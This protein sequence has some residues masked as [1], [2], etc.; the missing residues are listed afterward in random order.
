NGLKEEYGPID[1]EVLQKESSPPTSEDSEVVAKLTE[2]V[3]KV[4]EVK[5]VK[6]GFGGN[7]CGAFFRKAGFQTA[8]WST[9]DGT[10]H[11]PNEYA[12]ID[13]IVK[14]AQVFAILPFM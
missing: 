3:E 1:M 10:A 14:D 7:T 8:V 4:R 11:Q 13:N 5:P 6:V 2:A 12:V 9:I